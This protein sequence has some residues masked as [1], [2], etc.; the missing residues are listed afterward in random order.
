MEISSLEFELGPMPKILVDF[1][2]IPTVTLS[3]N[4]EVSFF[5]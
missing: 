2:K 5:Y 3:M 1:L 4:D